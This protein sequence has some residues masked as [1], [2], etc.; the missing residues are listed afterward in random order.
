MSILDTTAINPSDD[1]LRGTALPEEGQV[2]DTEALSLA[3][4]LFGDDGA[5]PET[6]RAVSSPVQDDPLLRGF[7]APEASAGGS[8]ESLMRE[9]AL[10][11]RRREQPL[12]A[13]EQGPAAPRSGRTRSSADKHLVVRI[14]SS[15]FAIPMRAVLEVMTVPEFITPPFLV[16]WVVGVIHWRGEILSLTDLVAYG[17]AQGA[18]A[19]GGDSEWMA[20]DSRG[21]ARVV[22]VRD[23]DDAIRSGW[24]VDR[25]VG[26]RSLPAQQIRPVPPTLSFPTSHSGGLV[27]ADGATV[28]VLD[29]DRVLRDEGFQRVGATS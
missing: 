10:L 2:T 18:A 20:N 29:V 15:A 25:V 13:V 4:A 3:A 1:A 22:V 24:I 26:L 8:L 28:L 16:D 11:A 7:T 6:P 21:V 27:E 19:F 9:L 17:R 12:A 14:A 23:T 5:T